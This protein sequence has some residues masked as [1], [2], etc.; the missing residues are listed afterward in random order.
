MR[1][2]EN[3]CMLLLKPLKMW[4]I[5]DTMAL[6]PDSIGSE[7]LPPPGSTNCASAQMSWYLAIGQPNP[8]LLNRQKMSI[9]Q[10]GTALRNT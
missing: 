4:A 2:L 6:I 5:K 3:L 7:F 8:A 10:C 9:H 1:V